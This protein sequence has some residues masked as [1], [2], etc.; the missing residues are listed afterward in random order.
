M[1]T[2]H[3]GVG[4]DSHTKSNLGRRRKNDNDSDGDGDDGV[5]MVGGPPRLL[6]A[7]RRLSSRRHT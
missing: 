3:D 6:V 2:T 5:V 7:V 4:L 1:L